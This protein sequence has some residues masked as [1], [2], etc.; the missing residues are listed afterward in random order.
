MSF[1]SF[2]GR[3]ERHSGPFK[4][5]RL[6]VKLH[7]AYVSAIVYVTPFYFESVGNSESFSDQKCTRCRL[8]DLSKLSTGHRTLKYCDVVI[9]HVHCTLHG[10]T[11]TDATCRTRA[12]FV[13]HVAINYGNI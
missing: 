13:P 7:Q 6:I 2:F 11:S 12:Q 8:A 3:P 10:C 4:T 1:L 5:T 9:E